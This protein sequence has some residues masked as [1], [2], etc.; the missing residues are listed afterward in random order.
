MKLREEDPERESTVSASVG[1]EGG[2]DP[3]EGDP[4][5]KSVTPKLIER[6]ELYNGFG[7][8]LALAFELAV[9]PAIFGL[10]G[11]GLDR[12]LGTLPVFTITLVLAC[13]VGLGVRQFYGYDAQMKV[14]EAAGP[15]AR[16]P[17]TD[18]DLNVDAGTRHT[19]PE[20]PAGR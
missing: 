9:T 15:W 7:N 18:T 1:P 4:T 5:L 12:W 3:S 14:H 19:P 11:Y 10:I 8:G 13:V 20:A 17:D 16:K 6:Q 2:G